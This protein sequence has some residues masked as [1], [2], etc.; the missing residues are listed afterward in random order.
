MASASGRKYCP[1]CAA[2]L[3]LRGISKRKELQP[4]IARSKI[5]NIDPSLDKNRI[6]RAREMIAKKLDQQD[7]KRIF[8]I[9]R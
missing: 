5:I 8:K 4:E 1:R 3:N 9:E 7:K 6:I 2:K